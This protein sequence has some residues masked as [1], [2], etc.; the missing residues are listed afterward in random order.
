M[1]IADAGGLP[2][3]HR[4]PGH[5]EVACQNRPYAW[6]R[7]PSSFDTSHSVAVMY[8]WVGGRWAEGAVSN[9]PIPRAHFGDEDTDSAQSKHA[10][11]HTSAWLWRY[12]VRAW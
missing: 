6:C 10:P 12:S 11:D 9:L 8:S 3:H 4:R 1:S 5:A 7:L 2:R